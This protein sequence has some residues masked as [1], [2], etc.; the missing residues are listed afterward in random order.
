MRLITGSFGGSAVELAELC[1]A[2]AVYQRS[3]PEDFDSMPW[4]WWGIFVHRY[5][6]MAKRQG[7]NAALAYIARKYKRALKCC[8]GVDV[9]AIPDGDVEV[10]YAHLSETDRVRRVT[11]PERANPLHEAYG[12]ADLLPKGEVHVVDY[13][14][15]GKTYDPRVGQL[16]HLAVCRR[17]ELKAESEPAKVSIVGVRSDGALLWRTETVSADEMNR[18]D[19]R[20]RELHLRVLHDRRALAEAQQQPEFKPGE[21]CGR[22]HLNT[23]CPKAVPA[24][25]AA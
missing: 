17:K 7:R 23:E 13:K 2:S 4:I 16:L 19:H 21:H 3:V 6:E 14:T 8:M 18:Y 5:L 25:P 15:G 9:N 24:A 22:C 20:F 11:W 10:G 12:K 1:P